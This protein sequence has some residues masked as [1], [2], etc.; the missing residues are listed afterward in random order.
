MITMDKWPAHPGL[1]IVYQ[2]REERHVQGQFQKV[3]GKNEF[4][5]SE[6]KALWLSLTPCG[7]L[8]P[9]LQMHS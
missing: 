6:E 2:G 4:L 3:N 1:P 7:S 8:P 5:P 9:E